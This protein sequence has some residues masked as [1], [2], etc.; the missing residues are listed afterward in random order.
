LVALQRFFLSNRDP[1][2]R[3]CTSDGLLHLANSSFMLSLFSRKIRLQAAMAAR[4]LTAASRYQMTGSVP[5]GPD[6]AVNSWIGKQE[7]DKGS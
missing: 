3:E 7:A 2:E 5:V 4:C 6:I 1:F